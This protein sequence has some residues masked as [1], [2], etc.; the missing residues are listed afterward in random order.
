MVANPSAS[1]VR[2]VATIRRL[3]I[4][5][6]L[7]GTVG[8]AGELLLLGHFESPLQFVPLVLLG[9]GLAVVV[10]QLAAPRAASV[11]ALQT[12]AILYLAAGVAGVG[13][14]YDGNASFELDMYPSRAGVEL[15]RKALTGATPVLAPGSLALLGLV[16][17][18]YTYKHPALDNAGSERSK[19][20]MQ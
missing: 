11:R 4:T 8:T 17:V 2:V 12:I 15:V 3:L 7:L 20:A 13:L 18:A 14:H 5:T 10:W 19:E 9:L 1:D 16:G 6:L